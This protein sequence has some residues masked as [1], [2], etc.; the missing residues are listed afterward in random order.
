MCFQPSEAVC[1]HNRAATID[2]FLAIAWESNPNMSWPCWRGREW[3]GM[4][5]GG[6][7]CPCETSP[8][9]ES[10]WLMILYQS[11]CLS[12]PHTLPSPPSPLSLLSHD[13][14]LYPYAEFSVLW[15]TIHHL[16]HYSSG[17]GNSSYWAMKAET[18]SRGFPVYPRDMPTQGCSIS[19][20]W[21]IVYYH[22]CLGNSIIR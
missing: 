7:G 6:G 14:S 15:K 13:T 9:W 20:C 17:S 1:H 3:G 22:N 19:Q 16:T 5:G 8:H 11:P 4:D 18:S 12:S 10:G 2:T 21:G